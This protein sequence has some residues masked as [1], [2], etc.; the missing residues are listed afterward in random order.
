MCVTSETQWECIKSY[1]SPRFSIGRRFKWWCS[2]DDTMT[3]LHEEED[4]QRQPARQHPANRLRYPVGIVSVNDER[5]GERHLAIF[6]H[7]LGIPVTGLLP[8][9]PPFCNH[10]WKEEHLSTF[11]ARFLSARHYP[12][13]PAYSFHAYPYTQCVLHKRDTTRKSCG[14]NLRVYNKFFIFL[15]GKDNPANNKEENQK[16]LSYRKAYPNSTDLQGTFQRTF[17]GYPYVLKTFVRTSL[18]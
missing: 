1:Y 17:R 14:N 6:S 13:N 2:P 5:D 15:G 16:G 9:P 18:E 11:S 7:F 12:Y 10:S 4:D 3:Q 8:P